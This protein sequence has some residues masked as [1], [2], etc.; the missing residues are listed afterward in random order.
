MSFG[1]YWFGVLLIIGGLLCDAAALAPP[2]LRVVMA[3]LVLLG[4]GVVA[5]VKATREGIR[6]SS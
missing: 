6:R 4:I 5:T 1:L 3:A 2:A